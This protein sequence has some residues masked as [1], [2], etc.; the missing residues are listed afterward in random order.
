MYQ[1]KYP[2]WKIIALIA[3]FFVA[4]TSDVLG[5]NRLH[6]ELTIVEDNDERTLSWSRTPWLVYYKI[7]VLNSPPE[8]LSINSPAQGRIA[9]Y[10]T[11]KNYLVIQQ[12]FPVETYWRVITMSLRQRPLGAYSNWVSINSV[13]QAITD[14]NVKAKP[15][16]TVHHTTEQPVSKNPLLTWSVTPGAVYYEL[17]F[18]PNMPENPNGTE[19]SRYSLWSTQEVY[20]NGYIADVSWAKTN[21]LY[22]RVR[23]IDYY[24]KPLGVFSDAQKIYVDS[25]LSP[26]LKPYLTVDFNANG[27]VT[28][29]YPVYAWIP[30][31]GATYYEVEVCSQLPENPYGID[32]SRYRIWHGEGQGYDLYDAIPRNIP[33]TY[34]WRVRGLDEDRKPIGGYSDVGTFIVDLSKGNYSACFGDSITHGGGAISYSPSDLEYGYETYLDF[35]TI[36]LGRSGDTIDTIVGRFDTDVLPFRP[37]YLIILGGTN[38]LR[39]GT[40]GFQVI[41]ELMDLRNKC[42]AYGIR[43]IF[44]TLPPINPDAIKRAFEEESAPHWREELDIVNQ[45]IRQQKYYID[46]EPFLS[47][48]HGLLPERYAI[49]GLHPDIDGKRV[50]GQIINENWV[51]VTR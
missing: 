10:Q 36:N 14:S 39:G 20:K 28:P 29:L 23:A 32:P 30:I 31:P 21:I 6:P 22:W 38:S 7:E 4:D 43:P 46:I 48:D 11:F 16:A 42:Q 37:Q 33:G 35:P 24:G 26:P 1:V 12:E 15:V 41:R 47:N 51:R 8:T 19:L 50:M 34:Y 27:A 9:T 18:L 2:F 3:V 13:K 17:E 5:L 49:D 44:L 25:K 45:F 40:T